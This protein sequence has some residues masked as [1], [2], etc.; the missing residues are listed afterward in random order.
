VVAG[1]D[2]SPARVYF[3]ALELTGHG[4]AAYPCRARQSNSSHRDRK[5]LT[6]S[7]G[8]TFPDEVVKLLDRPLTATICTVN[9]DRSPQA[10]VVWFERRGGEIVL[11]AFAE[12]IK[13]RNIR[14]DPSVE[15][16]VIDH[17]RERDPGV[18]PYVRLIGAAEVR[19]GEPGLPDRLAIRYGNP[20][21]YPRQLRPYVNIHMTTKRVT[22]WGPFEGG[23]MDGWVPANAGPVR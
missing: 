7:D 17:N 19:T 23:A 12:S 13:V 20:D 8:V 15:V 21:G 6:M 16:I 14:H 9:P 18:P 4:A 2:R 5:S 11:F 22:G 3:A 1:V 10:T